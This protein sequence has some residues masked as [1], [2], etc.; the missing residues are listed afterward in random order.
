[1]MVEASPG[2]EAVRL[3][4]ISKAFGSFKAL[5]NVSVTLRY[6]E[7]HALV[8]ENGAGKSTLMNVLYG[9]L[10]PSA[11]RML[12]GGQDVGSH[13]STR[14]AI[15]HQIGMIH[16]H[17]SLVMEHSVL[18]NIVMPTLKWTDLAPKW[19]QYRER[20][21]ELSA[22]FGFELSPDTLVGK[23][24]VGQRQ[25]VE[26]LKMLYQGAKILILDEPTAVLTPQQSDRLL[27]MLLQFRD[28]GYAVVI[29]THKLEH[30]LDLADHITVLRNGRQIATVAKGEGT[31]A[32][33]ARM[34]VSQEVNTAQRRSRSAVGEVV[35]DMDNV[36]L[37]VDG[38]ALLDKISLQVREGEILGVAGVAGN[39]QSELAETIIGLQSTTAGSI[40]IYGKELGT[41]S[42][43]ARRRG[44]IAIIPE[45]RHAHAVVG[46]MD[47]ASNFIMGHEGEPQFSRRGILNRKNIAEFAKHCIAEFDVRTRSA[48]TKLEFLSGGNQQKVV[49]GR[50]L[51]ANPRLIIAHEPARGLDFAA[52]AYIRQR[53]VQAAEAGAGVLLISSDLDELMELSTRVVV[54]YCGRAVGTVDADAY[55]PQHFGSL[56]AGAEAA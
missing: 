17:F 44:G 13:W 43:E 49:I 20:F 37:D 56:M 12:V 16:Q 11:G 40:S 35:L 29:I 21:S 10:Q 18:D 47:I 27:E 39:G 34:M 1:M 31:I 51:S 52:T 55:D 24:S 3:E 32:D 5:D 33:I 23:L 4:G 26:I 25:Q 9:I 6:G 38:V 53:L 30:A 7:I 48:E 50:E 54:L 14:D 8:G 46:E 41:T 22:Q 45:D 15:A 36:S 19:G 28:R 42:V 2:S